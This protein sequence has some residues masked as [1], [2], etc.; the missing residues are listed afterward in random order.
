M[1][2]CEPILVFHRHQAAMPV[3]GVEDKLGMSLDDLLKQNNSLP[4]GGSAT[5]S[6]KRAHSSSGRAPKGPGRRC[7]V[8]NMS[9]RTT[10][11]ELKDFF[12][13]A[14]DVVHAKVLEDEAGASK[15]CGI[16]EFSTEEEANYAIDHLHD[17]ELNGRLLSVREDREDKEDGRRED[18]GKMRRTSGS[19]SP[20]DTD[21]RR[22]YVGNL[23]YKTSW[24]DLKDHFKSVGKVVYS[25]V[26]EEKPGWSKGCGIIEFETPEEA[27]KAIK[28]LHDT[29]L[30]GR[31]I[32]VR[33]DR[34]D[35]EARPPSWKGS[36]KSGDSASY[37]D[38]STRE[39]FH[40][41]SRRVYVGNLSYRTSWQ[42]L[43][44]HFRKAGNVVYTGIM[45]ENGTGRS[46]GC[47]IVEF[48]TAREAA[49]AMDRLHDTMLDGRQIF[50]REDREDRDLR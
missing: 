17:R 28:V 25:G 30:R 5:S 42:D 7:Y 39:R 40:S 8:G 43:K 31:P 19:F 14:G 18:R 36:G 48:E 3:P 6:G 15:G 16:V 20:L 2:R 47:G 27:A 26:M 41:E 21:S 46:K 24:Q 23:S 9:F 35:K 33:E 34:E 37:S 38:R 32:F 49:K 13:Q 45:E 12:R 29:E 4:K 22:C 1:S 11:Q 10:W 44:D 50:V